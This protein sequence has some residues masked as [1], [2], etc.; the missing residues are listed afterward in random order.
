MSKRKINDTSGSKKEEILSV[1]QKKAC[2]SEIIE[3]NP[4]FETFIHLETGDLCSVCSDADVLSEFT[5]SKKVQ[6]KETGLH[7]AVF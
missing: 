5:S 6:R 7:K 2:L 4:V 1:V 3:T